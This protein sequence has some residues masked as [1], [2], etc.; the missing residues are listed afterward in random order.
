MPVPAPVSSLDEFS[1]AFPALDVFP[2]AYLCFR[3]FDSCIS[4]VHLPPAV[5]K[6]PQIDDAI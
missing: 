2:R 4:T 1:H 5:F 6:A 3:R